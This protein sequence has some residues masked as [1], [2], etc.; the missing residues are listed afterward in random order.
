[1]D[2]QTEL[3]TE[4]ISL[5]YQ[6]PRSLARLL[7]L[8]GSIVF[9]AFAEV[10]SAV[11]RLVGK[12]DSP[13]GVVIYYHHVPKDQ[14]LRFARQMDHLLRWVKPLCHDELQE[15]PRDSRYAIVT[16]DDG[17]ISFA[18][19]ALPELKLR[20]IP[21]TMFAI[22]GRLGQTVDGITADRLVSEEQLRSMRS[23]LV[24]IGSHTSTHAVMTGLSRVEALNELRESRA[25]LQSILNA[26]VNLF[27]FPY[28][29][30]D[31]SLLPLCLEAGYKCVFTCNPELAKPGQFAVGRIRVDPS[32]WPL[33]FHLKL[34]GAY[35]WLPMAI[36]LKRKI[37]SLIRHP[38]HTDESSADI[39][40]S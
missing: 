20:G 14:K 6:S 37:T 13:S 36:K 2:P 29:A 18:E 4:G 27:C 32:D 22:S 16:A 28:G 7:K 17:W 5:D 39:P 12:K 8:A 23:D 11:S 35:R 1:M 31:E 3:H 19:N 15:V 25:K 24:A 33:E 40:T 21:V 38:T 9:Y 30:F 10:W 26:D 34:M